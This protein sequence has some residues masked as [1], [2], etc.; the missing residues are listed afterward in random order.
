MKAYFCGLPSALPPATCSP[1]TRRLLCG[2]LAI[3]ASGCGGS[4][5]RTTIAD[6]PPP[7]PAAEPV[8]PARDPGP[9]D[10]VPPPPP[11]SGPAAGPDPLLQARG[12]PA[13][14]RIGALVADVRPEPAGLEIEV[15]DSLLVGEDVQFVAY[16]ADGIRM[17][18]VRI[19]TTIDSRFAAMEE[20]FIHGIAEGEAEVRM[21]I[22][23]PPASGSGPSEIRTFTARLRVV[24]PP[25][26]TVEIDDP[27]VRFL[28]GS[29]VQ[30]H[31]RA[32]G[33]DGSPR[34]MVGVEWSSDRRRLA[35][36]DSRGFVHALLP[37]R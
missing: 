35:S 2:L 27:G 26:A 31:A 19:L 3:L 16:N 10:S 33:G 29:V 12:Y 23:A 22:Q 15:G 25:V 34:Q 8:E 36:V 24:G 14:V 30:L 20:G 4:L 6:A 28:A 11:E 21:A 5:S 32:L 13:A 18:G 37:G 1:F 17:S 9:P 7:P